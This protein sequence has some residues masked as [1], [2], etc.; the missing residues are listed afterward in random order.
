M[1]IW[2]FVETVLLALF[3]PETYGPIL[4]KRKAW[5]L[6]KETGDDRYRAPIESEDK[7]L[8]RRLAISCYKPFGNY[9]DDQ[10]SGRVYLLT[11]LR[12]PDL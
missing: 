12:A 1:C 7:R 3:V 11:T 10:F 5:K 2:V 4:L 8:L 6:R 9:L